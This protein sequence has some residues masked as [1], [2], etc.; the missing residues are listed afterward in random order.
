MDIY[1]QIELLSNMVR[2]LTDYI[3][4]SGMCTDEVESYIDYCKDF[5]GEENNEYLN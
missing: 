3:I 4:Q 2:T 1:E 5:V